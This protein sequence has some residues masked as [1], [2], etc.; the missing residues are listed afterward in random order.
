MDVI[1]A[2]EEVVGVTAGWRRLAADELPDFERFR[3]MMLGYP[4]GEGR[5]TRVMSR[6]TCP[7]YM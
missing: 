5:A 2:P 1:V 7:G 3:G 4:A 6:C